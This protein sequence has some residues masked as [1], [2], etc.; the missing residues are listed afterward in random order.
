MD[1]IMNAKM[2]LNEHGSWTFILGGNHMNAQPSSVNVTSD[3]I[4]SD[5]VG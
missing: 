4:K 1:I 3:Q 5:K 2:S